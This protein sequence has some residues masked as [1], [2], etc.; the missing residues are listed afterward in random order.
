MFDAASLFLLGLRISSVFV[1][2]GFLFFAI[3]IIWRDLVQ[4]AATT[5]HR[6]VST[7]TVIPIGDLNTRNTYSQNEILFGRSP[8][9]DYQI[10]DETI[11]AKHARLFHQ[12][13]QWWIEDL[14][15][16]NGTYLNEYLVTTPTVLTN[17][18]Q[19]KLGN[20]FLSIQIQPGTGAGN[21][22][23]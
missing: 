22:S 19:I 1:L 20:F 11:S 17:G 8:D 23:S 18:D 15:S 5:T 16:F 21:Q 12:Y 3:R 14:S 9:C 6:L 7:I 13:N 4:Q 2:Y 10:A